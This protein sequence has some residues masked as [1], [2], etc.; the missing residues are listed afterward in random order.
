M[1]INLHAED[2]FSAYQNPQDS[3]ARDTYAYPYNNLEYEDILLACIDDD[4]A[5]MY[6]ENP[7]N[8]AHMREND[9]FYKEQ[10]K[11]CTL[12]WIGLSPTDDEIR[13]AE[14]DNVKV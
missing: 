10:N 5:Y 9:A 1:W 6:N 4:N 13:A 3:Y 12:F 7:D 8:D 11:A 2:N 14:G